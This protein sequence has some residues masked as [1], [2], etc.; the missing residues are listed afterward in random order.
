MSTR[1]EIAELLAEACH[2]AKR[3]M[4]KVGSPDMP[5]GWDECHELIDMLLTDMEAAT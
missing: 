4:P 1:T 5:T 3:Q 2:D